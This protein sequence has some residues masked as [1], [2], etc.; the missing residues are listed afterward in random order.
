[1]QLVFLLALVEPSYALFPTTIHPKAV[2]GVCHAT[3]LTI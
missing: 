2:R 1:M 3:Q